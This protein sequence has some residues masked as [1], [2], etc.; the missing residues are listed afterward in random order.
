LVSTTTRTVT[1]YDSVRC[2]F[3]TGPGVSLCSFASSCS[4]GV[5]GRAL[6]QKDI[7]TN[8]HPL[9]LCRGLRSSIT[10]GH[11]VMHLLLTPTTEHDKAEMA[12]TTFVEQECW[13][14]IEPSGVGQVLVLHPELK[15]FG[16]CFGV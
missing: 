13:V 12:Y 1:P 5:P 4:Q 2:T 9:C 15:L 14:S 16:V 3:Y 6:I 7:L 8:T 11:D 10:M